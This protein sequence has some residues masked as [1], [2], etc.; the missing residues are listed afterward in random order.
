MS[1]SGWP[2]P[3]ILMLIGMLIVNSL[4]LIVKYLCQLTLYWDYYAS[5]FNCADAWASKLAP[6][7]TTVPKVG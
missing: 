6:V 3:L 4:A 2:S 1:I 7:T 5:Q